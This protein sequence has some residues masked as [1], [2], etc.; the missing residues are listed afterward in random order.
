MKVVPTPFPLILVYAFISYLNPDINWKTRVLTLTYNSKPYVIQAKPSLI[1]FIHCRD[2]LTPDQACPAEL[3]DLSPE[4][5]PPEQLSTLLSQHLSATMA[6]PPQP[7][8]T[9]PISTASFPEATFNSIPSTTLSSPIHLLVACKLPTSYIYG[10]TDSDKEDIFN[11]MSAAK[12]PRN[13]AKLKKKKANNPV[14][15]EIDHSVCGPPL[16]VASTPPE[17]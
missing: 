8:S 15:T 14:V 16:K 7:L 17:I 11:Q 3:L 12:T 10:L 13:I 5:F 9:S 1:F 6:I 2:R 4:Q